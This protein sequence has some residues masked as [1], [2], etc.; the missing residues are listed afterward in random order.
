MNK[1][2]YDLLKYKV[3]IFPLI[4]ILVSGVL[5]AQ[6][7]TYNHPELEWKTF[8][9]EHF[10]I[11]YHQGTEWTAL[12]TAEVA[13]SVYGPITSFYNYEPDSKTD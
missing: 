3:F 13:E 8:E 5:S 2:F 11:H 10:D 1:N 12:K 9:T 4:L 6:F 7:A